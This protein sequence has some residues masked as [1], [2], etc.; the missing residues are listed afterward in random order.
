M[1]Y[2][3]SL[4]W[5]VLSLL[6]SEAGSLRGITAVARPLLL[7]SLLLRKFAVKYSLV[8]PRECSL[9]WSLEGKP[10]LDLHQSADGELVGDGVRADGVP[11]EGSYLAPK[12]C[13][14]VVEG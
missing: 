5:D 10:G 1:F 7:S 8:L 9:L 12:S 4:T 3:F 14:D 2:V 6:K 11:V 13:F